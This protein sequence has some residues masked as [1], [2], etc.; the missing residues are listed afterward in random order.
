MQTVRRK[1]RK[2]EIT[3]CIFH[4]NLFTNKKYSK[5]FNYSFIF[6]ILNC[7]L[8]MNILFV[9]IN[10][11]EDRKLTKDILSDIEYTQFNNYNTKNKVKYVTTCHKNQDIFWHFF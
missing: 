2:N 1:I 3:K 8:T 6:T 4:L 10:L 5:I 9:S 11:K 7:V